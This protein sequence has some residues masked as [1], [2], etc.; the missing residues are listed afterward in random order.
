MRPTLRRIPWVTA[1]VAVSALLAW[2]IPALSESWV[3]N[4]SAILHGEIWRLW[5]GNLVHFSGSHLGWD[6][7]VVVFT[8]TWIEWSRFRGG[9]WLWFVAPPC[10]SLAMLAG[11]PH[12]M[13]YG[14]L[15]GVAV[16]NVV[17]ACLSEWR[18]GGPQKIV[19]GTVLAL[20]GVKI[21]WEF[22]SGDSVFA[23]FADGNVKVVPL[24]HL[25]GAG[26]AAVMAWFWKTPAQETPST[27]SPPAPPLENMQRT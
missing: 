12:L 7:F 27:N 15:S 23:H 4:R 6:L 21:C 25:A 24:S 3:Y 16:A 14:G 19:W 10:I 13:R 17:F 18:S 9:R 5:T 8:G 11:E 20:V 22:C 1:L 26:I 2:I